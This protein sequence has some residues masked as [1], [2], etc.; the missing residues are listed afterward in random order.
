MF[1]KLKPILFFSFV[2][3]VVNVNAFSATTSIIN[4]STLS[5]ENQKEVNLNSIVLSNYITIQ[6]VKK[7]AKVTISIKGGKFSINDKAF[8]TS[9]T[10]VTNG[11]RVRIQQTSAKT[12]NTTTTSILKVGELQSIF[13]ST[14][15]NNPKLLDSTPDIFTFEEQKNV[16][17]N[18]LIT[19]NTITIQGINTPT[20]VSIVGGEYAINNGAFL[21]N[22]A[23]INNGDKITVRLFS[24]P[25]HNTITQAILTIG[26][27]QGAFSI[28][29]RKSIDNFFL[30]ETSSGD[31]GFFSTYF[32]GDVACAR[33]HNNLVD[34]RG[35]DVAIQQ[36][37]SATMM[38]NASRDPLW[39]AKVR[40]ELNRNPQ[41]ASVINDKCTRCH[42][43]MANFE[44]QKE[45]VRLTQTVFDE[46]QYGLL[47]ALHP[48]HDAAMS[49]VSCTLC[50]QIQSTDN[51]GKL[52]GFSGGYTIGD[53]LFLYGQ[54][55]NP[56]T[57][58]MLR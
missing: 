24:S 22:N 40:S 9:S 42:A 46:G 4:Q 41:L 56:V 50:H 55:E 49:G 7:N 57:L 53:N 33:C 51:L 18:S 16:T 43:P 20:Q 26:T 30:P 38:A 5:F 34:A 6:D 10:T 23:Y 32:Q 58:E 13:S 29:T 15:I 47:N 39:K 37:W 28:S 8:R 2:L 31:P 48:K 17:T 3:S 12:Y 45:N 54:Y 27:I 21:K 25:I 35:N 19:S 1:N 14:T 44:A 11:N 36:D 52:S